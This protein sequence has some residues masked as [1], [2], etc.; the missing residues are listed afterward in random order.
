MSDSSASSSR[1]FSLMFTGSQLVDEE[2]LIQQTR[3]SM[4]FFPENR[5]RKIMIN[6][7]KFIITQR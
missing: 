3:A 2:M 7:H 1:S 5:F 4:L 6:Q